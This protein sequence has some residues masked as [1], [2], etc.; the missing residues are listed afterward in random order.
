MYR[1]MIIVA[2][3]L[4]AVVIMYTVVGPIEQP[5]EYHDFADKRTVLGI[6]YFGDVIT[7]VPFT[8]VGLWGLIEYFR[9]RG[10]GEGRV[11]VAGQA[12]EGGLRNM[13]FGFLLVFVG[14]F[15]TGFG[16]G[17]YHLE[18]T[19]EA[20]VYDRACMAVAL[21]GL[22]GAV[23]EDRARVRVPVWVYLVLLVFGVGSVFYW[24]WTEHQG[25]G[26]LRPYAMV[27]YG[28]LATVI[29]ILLLWPTRWTHAHWYWIA[30]GCYVGAKVTEM[31]DKAIWEVLVV[32]SGHNIKHVLAA[33]GGAC[34]IVMLRRRQMRGDLQVAA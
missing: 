6:P 27:Q 14:L 18:P 16:S 26:D 34:L 23:I 9:L 31:T 4:L 33:L 20:L 17:Y 3:N 30:I 28:G 29:L 12:G 24:I 7:N 13:N 22:V 8:I 10:Q 2:V 1:W 15:L 32:V 21:A 19:N 25:G 5:L 11:E